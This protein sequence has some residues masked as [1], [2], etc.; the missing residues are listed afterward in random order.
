MQAKPTM[1]RFSPE[2]S[3]GCQ[4]AQKVKLSGLASFQAKNETLRV[5]F[6][7]S[8]LKLGWRGI[9]ELRFSYNKIFCITSVEIWKLKLGHFAY[10]GNPAWL[11][12]GGPWSPVGNH[13]MAPA[14][15]NFEFPKPSTHLLHQTQTST[16]D[17]SFNFMQFLDW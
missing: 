6:Q 3:G 15:G 13:Q 8:L 12:L 4:W 2:F 5:I 11:Y 10:Y 9:S 7:K 16:Y 17:L 1:H 14:V